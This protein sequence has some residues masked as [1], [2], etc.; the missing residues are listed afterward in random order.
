MID[1]LSNQPLHCTRS[2]TFLQ[3]NIHSMKALWESTAQALVFLSLARQ[4]RNSRT[5]QGKTAA[6]CQPYLARF[7]WVPAYLFQSDC[8]LSACPHENLQ[9]LS[10]LQSNVLC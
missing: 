7:Y 9:R 6:T 10:V 3:H 4:L 8:T 2:H 5:D 1:Q